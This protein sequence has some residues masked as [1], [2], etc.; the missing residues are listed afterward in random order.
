MSE[1][2]ITLNADNFKSEVLE[3]DIPVLVDMWA[4]WCGPCKLIAP[5]VEQLAEENTG[6]IKV[7]KM[8]VDDNQATAQQY[9]IQS[10][11]TL[12]LFKNG[13]AVDRI[14]GIQF[15]P[16]IQSMIDSHL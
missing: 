4:P 6:K 2:P 12:L 10:I 8:N 7:A 3:S 15:K 16:K 5:V 11:P 9:G 1:T 13:E 14:I